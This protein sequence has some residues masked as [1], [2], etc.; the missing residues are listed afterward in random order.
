MN[1]K[2][3]RSLLLIF[4]VILVIASSIFL[5]SGYMIPG[6][7]PI[8]MAIVMFALWAQSRLSYKNDKISK[9]YFVTC[10]VGLILGV[11][12]N[13]VA[14]IS[15]LVNYLNNRE[16]SQSLTIIGGADGPTSVFT[17]S[18]ST[19][20]VL[21]LTVIVTIILASMIAFIIRRFMKK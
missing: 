15:Q 17:E 1:E 12:I 2:K 9:T 16:A 10:S 21:F 18:S 13:I 3:L 5:I 11:I 20:A 4:S 8:T 14:A 6:V 19:N 7:M